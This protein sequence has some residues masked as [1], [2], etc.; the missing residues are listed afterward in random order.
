MSD[1]IDDAGIIIPEAQKPPLE[2]RNARFMR[3][4]GSAINIE[5]NHAEFGWI[6]YTAVC[7]DAVFDEVL[8][9]GEI[10]AYEAPP[11][12]LRDLDDDELLLGLMYL[13]ITPDMVDSVIAAMDGPD[14]IRAEWMW[15]RKQSFQ[16]NHWLI[17]DLG[18]A[19]GKTTEEVDEAW[20]Y[21]SG[22]V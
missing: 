6:P 21:A 11:P 15:R 7:G 22:G 14:R 19:F 13:N 16:R 3:G 9:S 8:L 12:V 17:E 20:L 2:F 18:A 5:L 10:A 4:D 1:K